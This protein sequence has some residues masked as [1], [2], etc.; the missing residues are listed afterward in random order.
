MFKK[1]LYTCIILAFIPMLTLA[2]QS[3]SAQ[4]QNESG[5]FATLVPPRYGSSYSVSFNYNYDTSSPHMMQLGIHDEDLKQGS[6]FSFTKTITHFANAPT[7]EAYLLRLTITAEENF[8]KTPLCVIEYNAITKTIV[9]ITK[10]TYQSHIKPI[11]T[12]T[13]TATHSGN[14]LF[15]FVINPE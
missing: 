9:W 6:L 3:Q 15:V 2:T 11:T 13:C 4:S 10:N 8:N 1:I 14:H 12:Y 5:F 7:L